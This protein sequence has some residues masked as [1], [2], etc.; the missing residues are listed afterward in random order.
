M[1]FPK[2]LRVKLSILYLLTTVIPLAIIVFV[3]PSYYQNVITRDSQTLTAATL[4]ALSRNIDTYLDDLNR[5][6][7]TP[8]LNNDVM[9]ALKLKASHEYASAKPSEQLAANQALYAT[10]P[11]YLSTTRQDILSTIILPYDGSVFVAARYNPSSPVPN[12]PFRQQTWYKQAIAAD[13]D[14]AFIN[15]HPQ[16]YL[17]TPLSTQVFSVARLIKDPDTAR[18]LAVIMADA[19]TV[20]LRNIVSGIKLN[21]SSI[22]AVFGKNEQLLYSSQPLSGRVVRALARKESMIQDSGDA[23]LPVI[24]KTA[25]APWSVVILLSQS[26]ITA[27]LQWLYIVGALF[28]LLGLCLTFLLFSILSRWIV[29]PFQ[30]MMGVMKQVQEGDLQTQVVIEGE[31]EIAILG[32]AFN[33]MITRL[34]ETIGREYVATLNQ[35][36]AEY[37]ALQ[38]QIQPHFLYNTLNGFI[39]LN[40]LGERQTLENA[41]IALSG[42]LRHVLSNEEWVTIKEEFLFLQRYCELQA[43]RFQEKMSFELHCEQ[44]LADFKIPKLLLQPLVE[45]AVI[46][47]IEPA[48]HPCLLH[49]CA[50]TVLEGKEEKPVI[51]ILVEDNGVGFAMEAQGFNPHLGLANVRERLKIAYETASFSISNA[52][53][54]G[55]HVIIEIPEA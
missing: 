31:D 53:G 50:T 15:P 48:D 29:T 45:N 9:I 19:D 36:N 37:R 6:T 32:N 21:V 2:T 55:T 34:D 25:S 42:L 23:Y 35:R 47:G 8:Y 3:M 11:Y 28:A 24:K 38:S 26:E 17:V 5:L 33:T 7:L 16:D 52:I 1:K 12:Y 22:I 20:V 39:G 41:I 27:Q 14:V 10:L 4:T 51:R 44:T 46:H 13:G 40:R 30:H 54:C 43:L 49:V 18:P